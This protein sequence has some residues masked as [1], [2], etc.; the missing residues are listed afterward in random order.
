MIRR[1]ITSLAVVVVLVLAMAV[2]AAAW[3]AVTSVGPQLV[4][5]GAHR[6]LR[7]AAGRL[8]VA[9]R[10]AMNLHQLFDHRGARHRFPSISGE[11]RN[12]DGTTEHVVF[13]NGRLRFTALKRLRQRPDCDKAQP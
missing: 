4:E 3:W 5:R 10:C 2:H 12:P 1:I 6:C 13:R 9:G 11:D 7:A 8:C